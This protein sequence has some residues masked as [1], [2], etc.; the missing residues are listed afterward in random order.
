MFNLGR[1]KVCLESEMVGECCRSPLAGNRQ[2][3]R[4]FRSHFMEV[5]QIHGRYIHYWVDGNDHFRV[6]HFSLNFT[7]LTTMCK[8][9]ESKVKHFFWFIG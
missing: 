9:L 7:T 4:N 3:I 5:M 8:I 1:E 2:L 6:N